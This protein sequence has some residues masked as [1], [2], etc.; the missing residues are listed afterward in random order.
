[1]RRVLTPRQLARYKFISALF[2]FALVA[3]FTCNFAVAQMKPFNEKYVFSGHTYSNFKRTITP[4]G[5]VDYYSN[6]RWCH[7]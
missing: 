4:T 2:A 6:Q 7:R 3:S 5:Y 1:M